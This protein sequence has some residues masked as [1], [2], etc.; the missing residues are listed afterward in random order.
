MKQDTLKQESRVLSRKNAR[1][2]TVDETGQVAG[3]IRTGAPCS[4]LPNGQ[5]DGPT[6]DC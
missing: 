6:L 5:L 3:G 1:E 4:L 2:L